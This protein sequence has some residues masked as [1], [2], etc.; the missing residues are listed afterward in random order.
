VTDRDMNT[1]RHP[2]GLPLPSVLAEIAD[3]AGLDVA[4]M[5]AEQRGGRRLEIARESALLAS[6]V[7]A[8]AAAK[9]ADKLGVGYR[10]YVP[11]AAYHLVHWLKDKGVP[12][13]EIVRRTRVPV[14]TIQ[15]WE[16]PPAEREQLSLKLL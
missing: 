15:R 9:I 1:G 16:K 11:L 5:I 14:R 8:D 12:R 10:V 13:A 2:F 7:G 3:V 4:M 6:W